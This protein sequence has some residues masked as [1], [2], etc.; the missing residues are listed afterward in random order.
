MDTLKLKTYRRRKLTYELID[1]TILIGPVAIG[2]LILNQKQKIELSDFTVPIFVLLFFL[3]GI[4]FFIRLFIGGAKWYI[5]Y[6]QSGFIEINTDGIN[7]DDENFNVKEI[8]RISIDATQ[9]KGKA[10]GRSGISDGTGNL[11][12]ISLANRTRIKKKIIIENMYQY[13]SLKELIDIL[14]L[15]GITVVSYWKPI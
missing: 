5:P 8:R 6:V 1:S 10:G 2:M 9:C 4:W 13:K 11:I 7:F 15:N 12:E 14:K 3:G